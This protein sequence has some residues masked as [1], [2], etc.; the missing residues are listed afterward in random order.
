MKANLSYLLAGLVAAPMLQATLA[1]QIT[2]ETQDLRLELSADGRLRSLTSKPSGIEYAWTNAPLPIASLYRGGQMAVASQEDYAEFEP[3]TYRSGQCYQASAVVLAGDLLTIRFDEANVTAIYRITVKPHYLAFKLVSL[4]GEPVDRID[5]MQLRIKRLPYLGPWI[6]V[7]CDERF[8]LCLCAGNIKTDAGMDQRP[9]FVEMRAVATREIALAGASAVLFGCNQPKEKF[10]DA[11]EIVERDF[12]M[13]PGAKNRRSPAQKCSYLWCTPAPSNIDQYVALAKRAGFGMLFFSYASFAKGAGHFE[14]NEQF[15][16]GIADLKKVT[17]RIRA[18]G[19]KVGLHL[20]YS[21]TDR[22]D[23]YV[24]PVPDDRLHTV[25]AFTLSS[26]IDDHTQTIGVRENPEGV[27][28][29]NERRILKLGKELIAYRDYTT[30]PPYQFIGCERGHL[31]TAT[32][33]HLAGQSAGLVDVDDWTRFIRFDQN[34]DI[35]DEAARRIAEIANATGPYDLVYFDG[36]EDVHDPFWYHVANAQYRVFQLLQP[37]PA[38]C[39]AA[40]SGHFSWHF[41]T[42]GNAYDVDSQHVKN[43]CHEISCRTAPIRALDFTP[44]NFGWIFQF[45]P[46]MGPDVLEYVLS[47]GA[48]WNCPSSLKLA[49]E[50]VGANPRAEDCFEVI[51]TWEKAR[52]AGNITDAQQAMLKTLD[53]KEYRYVKIWDAMYRPEWIDTYTK[54]VFKDQ[55][56][57]LFVNERGEYELVPIREVPGIAGGRVKAYL[58]QRRAHPTDTCVLLWATKGQINLTLPLAAISPVS[59]PNRNPTLNLNP[60]HPDLSDHLVVMRPFGTSLPFEKSGTD[61][62]I[63]VSTRRYLRLSGIDRQQATQILQSAR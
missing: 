17:D 27:T 49:P 39:E 59:S 4:E 51:K 31:K 21:K 43:Y 36:A 45:R 10:L 25:R 53:P 8:G 12:Q 50:E 18:A 14:F 40:M 62:V 55:E 54:R 20:H 3:P 15:P 38:D 16:N 6:D 34:T 11:M 32:S 42:R 33:V 48:A 1:A 29:T 13:P 60:N 57:H 41:V 5:L 26:A 19:L 56:H 9:D 24:T 46:E 63:P 35:Q 7:A 2:L 58:F 44:I 28:R 52:L 61:A 47:R 23:A 37:P 22:T 30:Q